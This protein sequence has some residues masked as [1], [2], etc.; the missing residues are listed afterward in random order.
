MVAPSLARRRPAIPSAEVGTLRRA[1]L[2]TTLIRIGLAVALIV[3]LALAFLDARQ[4]DPRPASFIPKGSSA[5]V[6]LDLSQSVTD[7][8]YRRIAN[9]LAKL[10]DSGQSI[11]LVAFSDVSYELFPPGSPPE[12]LRPFIHYFRPTP[13][14]DTELLGAS[15]PRNPWSAVFSGGTS[16]SK[17]LEQARDVIERDKVE[18]PSV[19]LIS[20]LDTAVSDQIQLTKTLA[21]FVS[22][23]VPMRVVPLFATDDDRRLFARFVGESN[24][25]TPSRLAALT[26][27]RHEGRLEGQNPT[28]LVLLAGLVL[29]ALALNE[30]WCR[31]LEV[32]GARS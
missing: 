23:G 9:T 29:I 25:V 22:A 5:I 30:W 8:V 18:N 1:W 14:Y 24:I 6:V 21:D 19:L 2:L 20:D 4:L 17:G 26:K 27:Q 7:P 16:I 13:G 32:P 11:G 3:L 10:S 15:Y 12:E 28:T 31:R